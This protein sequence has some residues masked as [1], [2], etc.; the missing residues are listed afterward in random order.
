MLISNTPE[1]KDNLTSL[2]HLYPQAFAMSAA[3]GIRGGLALRPAGDAG[4]NPG[5][6]FMGNSAYHKLA[7]TIS[8]QKHN[9]D[10]QYET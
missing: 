5:W 4:F 7:N 2:G 9:Q 8:R 10:N 1:D 3:A 6:I